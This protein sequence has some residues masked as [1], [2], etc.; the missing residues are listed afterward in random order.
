MLAYTLFYY[1]DNEVV[2]KL[3]N[4][5]MILVIKLNQNAGSPLTINAINI[6]L[7][8]PLTSIT[9]SQKKNLY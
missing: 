5:Q 9:E 2:I 1:E 6:Q 4:K 3:S 8:W 7:S